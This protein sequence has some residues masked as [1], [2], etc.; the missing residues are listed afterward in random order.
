MESS[1]LGIDLVAGRKL[2]PN[3]ATGNIAFLIFCT[4][5]ILQVLP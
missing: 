1:S 3:P 2:I 4:I 5:F